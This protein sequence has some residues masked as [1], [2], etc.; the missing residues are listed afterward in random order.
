M[1]NYYTNTVDKLIL[2]CI[3]K[4]I[5]FYDLI[6][7]AVGIHPI[8]IVN[9]LAR[10]RLKNLINENKYS[11]L[12]QSAAALPTEEVREYAKTLPIPHQIDYDW[13]FSENG[14]NY[15]VKFI[16]D[17]LSVNKGHAKI[18]FIGSPTLFRHY[19]NNSP[20]NAK[21]FLIDFN[22]TKHTSKVSLPPYAHIVNC[23]LNYDLETEIKVEQ[24]QADIIVIDPPWYPEY[25]KKFFE[26]SNIV[27]S[28]QCTIVGVFPPFLTRDSILSERHEI[29]N[30]IQAFGFEDLKFESLA[31]EYYT[32]PFEKKVLYAN[33]IVNFPLSFRRGDFFITK[34]NHACS[35]ERKCVKIIIR[36]G[37]WTEKS[38]GIVR[39]KLRQSDVSEDSDFHI[40]LDSLYKNDIYPSV[41]RRFK[42]HEKINVWTSGNRVFYCSNI[43]M[44]FLILEKL[45]DKNIISTLQDEYG[46]LISD[47]QSIQI[48]EAQEIIQLV[49]K[50]EL[51]EYG[52]WYD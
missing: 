5:C 52:E 34:R 46:E 15:F 45:D 36:N 3:D 50:A 40:R 31:I 37:G 44:L 42:G 39:F 35:D 16:D 4:T 28:N 49:V 33:E 19:C 24:I 51:E 13:R 29:N 22:A 18:V 11:T 26:I 23:N 2:E 48:I 43:P 47:V 9:S 30:Y 6:K 10:L 27:G 8:E 7:K 12:L 32:P 21:I 17:W 25:Y 41:S 14:K 20:Y 38:V 1:E